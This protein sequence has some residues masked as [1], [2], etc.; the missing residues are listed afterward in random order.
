[1]D[2]DLT[3]EQEMLRKF[4]RD[5]I[6][7]K[8]PK[9][10]VREMEADEK[11]YSPDVWKGMAELGW[12]GLAFPEEYGGG[13]MKFLDLAVLLEE[14]G[15]SCMPGPFFST[16]VLG[17][18]TIL[19]MG[20]KEQ[21]QEF[22]PRISQGKLIM[23]LALTE[24]SGT[25]TPDGIATRAVA[26]GSD[27]VIN[28]T[29]L[30][31]PDFNVADYLICVARTKEGTSADGITLFLVDARSPGISHTMLHGI[32]SDKQAEVVF[33]N[34]R[35]PAKNI[36]GELNKGWAAVE[37]IIERA[38]LGK[39]AEMIGGAQQVLEMTVA[40]AKERVQFDRPI[41]SFQ[42]VQHHCANMVA[43]VEG[44]KYITYE[45]A[46]RLSEGL[47]CA[48]EIAMTK[49]WVSEAYRRVVALSH[50]VHGAIGFTQDHDLHLYFRRAKA[51]ELAFGDAGFHREKVAVEMGL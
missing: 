25:Y 11:G 47:P 40:Y 10:Y 3:E 31:V 7:D 44:S 34:V 16:V 41:G 14:M 30:F 49:T 46:W 29:K 1:V 39:C 32:A 2:F 42:A 15:R 13:G 8:C 5:F 9:K 4:A 6:V 37:K 45:A 27:Y 28:G 35:V 17:G 26:Q 12:M 20:T 51:A 22:L 21:K 24:A 33:K 38:A 48:Q 18:M 50:Q 19:D 43:D 23:T 36:I